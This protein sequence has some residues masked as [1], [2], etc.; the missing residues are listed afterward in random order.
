MIKILG[1]DHV[2]LNVKD[3]NRSLEF[4]TRILGLKISE[5]EH[6]KPGSEYFLDCGASLV[7]LI[8]GDEKTG[9]HFLQDGGV[10]GNHLAF[11][12]DV[13]DFDLIVEKLEELKLPITFLKNPRK[14]IIG[15]GK[16]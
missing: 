10:G 6:Q 3:L 4:Y 9:T 12:V 15:L 7:G 14:S 8:Q 16:N 5:R 2:A 11:R 1:I 13:S